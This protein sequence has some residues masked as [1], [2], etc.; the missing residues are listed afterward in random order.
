MEGAL[1]VLQAHLARHEWAALGRPSIA[2]LSLCGYLFWNEEFGVDWADYPAVGTWLDR[3]RAL[4]G[5]VHP[6][7]LMPGHPLP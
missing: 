6:Y 1:G 3:I 2:D 4:P 5:W 7:E